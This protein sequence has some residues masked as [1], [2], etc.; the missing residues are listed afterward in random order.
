MHRPDADDART[1]CLT[2]D[3]RS[4]RKSID[5]RGRFRLHGPFPDQERSRAVLERATLSV[6]A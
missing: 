6:E 3:F 4:S 2:T 1:T 5:A